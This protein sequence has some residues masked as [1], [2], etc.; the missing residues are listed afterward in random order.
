MA[1]P[2]RMQRDF[3]R[4]RDLAAGGFYTTPAGMKDLR[5]VGNV[6]RTRFDGPPDDV[7]EAVGLQTSNDTS[8][9]GDKR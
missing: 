6:A 5:Y 8:G 9:R 3:A 7:L 4:Y 1:M 2:E